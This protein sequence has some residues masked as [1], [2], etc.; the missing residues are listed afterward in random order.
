MSDSNPYEK[1]IERMKTWLFGL[2]DSE[3]VIPLLETRLTPEEADFL[4]DIPFLPHAIEQLAEKLNTPAG[5]LME[6]LDSLAQRGLVFRHESRDTIRYALN[7]SLFVFFRSPFWPGESDDTTAKLAEL[8]NKYYMDGYGER[9]GGYEVR[10]VRALPVETSIK[11]TREVRPYEDLVQ[12]LDEVD[13]FCTSTCACR[14]RKN[15]DDRAHTCDHETLNC[16]HFGRLARYM[17]AQGMGKEITREEARRI[18]RDAAEEGLV[19]AISNIQSGMDTIC[20]CCRC[21]CMFLESVRVLQMQGIQASNYVVDI[22]GDTCT[23]CGLCVERCPVDALELIDEVSTLASASSCMGCGV[24]VYKCPSET[25]GLVHREIEQIY[26]K[27][28]REN[29]ILMQQENGHGMPME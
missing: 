20:N 14:H 16:L 2:P 29:A 24:C 23:G 25:L 18:L 21:C 11:D 12:V 27:N 15:L 26:P 5:E 7:D 8:S 17:V 6:K 10:A 3:A 22:D 13:Y 4:A 1:Y 19:H 9:F 28:F